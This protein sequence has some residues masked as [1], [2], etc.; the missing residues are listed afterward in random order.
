MHV[1]RFWT[2]RLLSL[3]LCV[4]WLK[5]SAFCVPC[6][7]SSFVFLLCG[8]RWILFPP[9]AFSSFLVKLFGLSAAL[10]AE[11]NGPSS[12]FSIILLHTSLSSDYSSLLFLSL[13]ARLHGNVSSFVFFYWNF[14]PT[15]FCF[16]SQLI[17]KKSQCHLFF[18]KKSQKKDI[19]C[20]AAGGQENLFVAMCTN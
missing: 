8:F 10:G 11:S 13:H 14:P 5:S 18:S 7:A 3:I 12:I 19:V 9:H 16:L 1:I 4:V 17:K 15:F 6:F 20:N 2:H